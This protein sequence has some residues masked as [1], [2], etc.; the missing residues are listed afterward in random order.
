VGALESVPQLDEAALLQAR[1]FVSLEP[2][3]IPSSGRQIPAIEGEADREQ[4]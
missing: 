3:V 1:L 2:V 4:S